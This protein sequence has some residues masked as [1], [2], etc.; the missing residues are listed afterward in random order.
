M[1]F[2]GACAQLSRRSDGSV[3]V[4]KKNRGRLR[5]MGNG[6]V[7]Q[8]TRRSLDQP[9]ENPTET[10]NVTKEKR[11]KRKKRKAEPSEEEVVHDQSAAI[12]RSR[13][14]SSCC[15]WRSHRGCPGARG[16]E[17]V[18]GK[19]AHVLEERPVQMPRMTCAARLKP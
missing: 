16:Q 19:L 10:G 1:F 3:L 7:A 15:H 14:A 9:D 6:N 5:S 2:A 17:D 11:G 4:R 18:A 8:A 12:A 13:L